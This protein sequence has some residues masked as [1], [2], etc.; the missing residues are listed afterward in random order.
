MKTCN[1][2]G[3]V[4]GLPPVAPGQIHSARYYGPKRPRIITTRGGPPEVRDFAGQ[5][6]DPKEAA[7]VLAAVVDEWCAA[8]GS[9]PVGQA[10]LL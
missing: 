5:L 4:C 2:Y 7:A 6:I 1:R 9:E 10:V 3:T 8:E